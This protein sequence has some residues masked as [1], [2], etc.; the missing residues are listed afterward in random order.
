MES[1]GRGRKRGNKISI[2]QC[3]CVKI[4]NPL[5]RWYKQRKKGE[6]LKSEGWWGVQSIA[7]RKYAWLMVKRDLSW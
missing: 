2:G 6:I 5:R 1:L 7:S 4:Q 3:F